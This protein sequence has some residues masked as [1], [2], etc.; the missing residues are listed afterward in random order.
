MTPLITPSRRYYLPGLLLVAAGGLG[1]HLFYQHRMARITG[2]LE[3][4]IAP[5][6][7]EVR[8]SQSGHHSI[9]LEYRSRFEGGLFLTATD[10]GDLSCELI[11]RATGQPVPLRRSWVKL[12]YSEPDRSGVVLFHFWVD[13]PG[14]YA[15]RSRYPAG[16][17]GPPVVLAVGE[18]LA[19]DLSARILAGL[20][21]PS[22]SVLI[23]LVAVW[24]VYSRREA[25][26][27][28]IFG[29]FSR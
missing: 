20:G 21:L 9:Y 19:G 15:L 8:L 22:G 17:P 5:G 1:L 12:T 16:A 23:G 18:G 4:G 28:G 2:D 10:P 13:R 6:E 27:R 25:S 3:R 29:R 24:I 7:L 26:K 14:T 11:S